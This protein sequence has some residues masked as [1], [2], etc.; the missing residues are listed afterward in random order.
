MAPYNSAAIAKCKP[1]CPIEEHPKCH[2]HSERL[3]EF[4]RSLNH[5]KCTCTKKSC[6][7]STKLLIS[8][9]ILMNTSESLK[10]VKLPTTTQQKLYKS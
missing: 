3:A 4:E 2:A 7:F 9:I 6:V 8:V 10:Y 1:L 5:K